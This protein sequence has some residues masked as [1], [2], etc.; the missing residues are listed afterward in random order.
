MEIV[1]KEEL[2]PKLRCLRRA[3]ARDQARKCQSVFCSCNR[4]R[5]FISYLIVI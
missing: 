2:W 3:E 4:P 1:D 5:C